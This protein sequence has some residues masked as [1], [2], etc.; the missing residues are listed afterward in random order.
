MPA[1]RR[2]AV[3]GFRAAAWARSQ[4]KVGAGGSDLPTTRAWTG[5]SRTARNKASGGLAL[6]PGI[7]VADHQGGADREQQ[8]AGGKDENKLRMLMIEEQA[9]KGRGHRRA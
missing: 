2:G 5:K 4:A 8:D 3:A 6:S 7:V 1:S 9:E